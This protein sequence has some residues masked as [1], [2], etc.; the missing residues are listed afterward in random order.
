MIGSLVKQKGAIVGIELLARCLFDD[1]QRGNPLGT[2][3]N[4]ALQTHRHPHHVDRPFL[5]TSV[6]AGHDADELAGIPWL[7]L[8]QPD[9][10]RAGRVRAVG[11]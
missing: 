7:Q 1:N 8:L 2:Y 10:A 9:G 11:G 3:P 5:C 6:A 4:A